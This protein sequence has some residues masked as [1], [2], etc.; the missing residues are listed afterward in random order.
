[1]EYLMPD[2]T[3]QALL[4]RAEFHENTEKSHDSINK[5]PSLTTEGPP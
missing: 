2:Y 1:M 3:T 5:E 4:F